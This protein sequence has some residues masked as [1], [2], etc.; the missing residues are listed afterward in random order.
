MILIISSIWHEVENC[1]Y[2]G[3]CSGNCRYPVEL[4]LYSGN[5]PLY[6]RYS[7]TLMR[8]TVALVFY[9]V[10]SIVTSH[11]DDLKKI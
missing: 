10:L 7:W 11:N 8:T 5:P 3:N 2:S 9:P 6:C 4:S 1:R